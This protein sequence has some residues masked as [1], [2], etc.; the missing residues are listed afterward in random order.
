MMTCPEYMPGFCNSLNKRST[1]LSGR[2]TKA[3][4]S[5]SKWAGGRQG[6]FIGSLNIPLHPRKGD[7]VIPPL[8]SMGLIPLMDDGYVK[9]DGW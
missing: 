2:T 4:S 9:Q 8:D 5:K 1:A 7:L 6:K 3:H